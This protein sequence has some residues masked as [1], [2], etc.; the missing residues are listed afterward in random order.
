MKEWVMESF[1]TM[2]YLSFI[3]S[4]AV[5]ILIFI[6]RLIYDTNKNVNDLVK[7]IGASNTPESILGRLLK[8]ETEA[9]ELRD[10]MLRE[11]YD[12]RIT[13]RESHG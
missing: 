3:T 12:R 2:T 4:I 10:W 8:V 11:G 1:S 6:G 13:V 5:A 7:A 9:K